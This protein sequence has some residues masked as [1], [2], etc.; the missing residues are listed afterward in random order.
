MPL[1]IFYA[2]EFK[3]DYKKLPEALQL[4][5]KTRGRLFQQDPF[6]ALLH[7]H[8]LTGALAPYW[9]F[10]VDSRNRVLFRFL[11]EGQV[12]LLRVGDHSLYRKK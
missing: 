5:L 6:H 11:G 1:D 2:P 7:T 10:S 9:S 12:M 3:R 8:K 4:L